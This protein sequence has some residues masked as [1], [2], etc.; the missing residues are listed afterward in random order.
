MRPRGEIT[1]ISLTNKTSALKNMRERE[2]EKHTLHYA[3][4]IGS[5]LLG[6]KC[7]H[8][9]QLLHKACWHKC[10]IICLQNE[11]LNI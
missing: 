2:R 3:V 1:D 7:K 6:L 10:D 4:Y 8:V 5:Y 11:N 9:P